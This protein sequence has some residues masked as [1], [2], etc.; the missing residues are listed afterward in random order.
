M[1]LDGTLSAVQQTI[2]A[3]TGSQVVHI[4]SLINALAIKLPAAGADTALNM[5][6]NNPDVIGAY[7][8]PVDMVDGG[9]A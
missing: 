9:I 4:L 7:D 5:L 2:V 8:D 6:L 1:F 3:L